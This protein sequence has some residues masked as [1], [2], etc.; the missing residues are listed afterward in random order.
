MVV[1]ATTPKTSHS[2]AAFGTTNSTYAL[3]ASLAARRRDGGGA[4]GALPPPLPPLASDGVLS[5]LRALSALASAAT[6]S[7]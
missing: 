1:C 4:G 3:P 6:S 5:L 7:A 2:D